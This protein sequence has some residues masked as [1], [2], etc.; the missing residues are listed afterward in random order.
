[1]AAKSIL[2]IGNIEGYTKLIGHA[3]M[4]GYQILYT[5]DFK[6]GLS[7]LNQEDIR[8]VIV[9]NT[10]LYSFSSNPV[11][12]LSLMK[13]IKLEIPVILTGGNGFGDTIIEAFQDQM[14]EALSP[15]AI[16]VEAKA[17]DDAVE[18]FFNG[19]QEEASESNQLIFR[20]RKHFV[21]LELNGNGSVGARATKVQGRIKRAITYMENHYSEEMSLD[22]IAHAAYMNP[23]HFCRLFKK[24]VGTTSSKYLSLLRVGKA[25]E[26]L[27][28]TE[29]TVTEICFRVGFNNLTHFERVFKGL[30]GMTPTAYRQSC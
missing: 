6:N 10:T 29:L 30:E 15:G 2:V 21:S 27:K 19:R 28:G 8:L 13:L 17:I 16:A 4:K 1:M 23:Y 7:L 11:K 24:Q 9:G 22:Q 12:N 14:P 25:K 3:L 26:L 5:E 18:C 20:R